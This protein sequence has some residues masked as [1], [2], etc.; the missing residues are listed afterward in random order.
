MDDEV[1]TIYE[2]VGGR[3]V[4]R[5][6]LDAFYDL[7]EGDDLLGPVFGG[8]VSEEHRSHVTDWW[9]EVMGGP[10]AYTREHGGYQHMLAKH[11]GLGIDGEQR[12]RF[13]SLLSRA[14]DAAGVPADPECR[15]AL[16]GYA[17]W[18][19]RLAVENSAQDAHP[20]EQAPVPHWGWG[21]APPYLG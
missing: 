1:P 2:W 20:V 8:V 4:F 21:V 16:M 3:A 18:G 11:R 15:A 7:V 5:A 12:L 9:C 17:E 14:A 6:W 13:V 19:T 10:D